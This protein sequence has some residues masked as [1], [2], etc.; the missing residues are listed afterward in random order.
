MGM[1]SVSQRYE[2]H[3]TH[4]QSMATTIIIIKNARGTN[5]S[6]SLLNSLGYSKEES[7]N[8]RYKISQS[9]KGFL[10]YAIFLGEL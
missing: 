10:L 2:Q 7:K 6:L 9:S 8:C 5:L 4:I 3:L 1:L